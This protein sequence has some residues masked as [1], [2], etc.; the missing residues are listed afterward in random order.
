MF[1]LTQPRK[2]KDKVYKYYS[3][4][5]SYREGKKVHIEILHRVGR[6]SDQEACQ[7][8]AILKLQSGK[9]PYVTSLEEVIFS[10]HWAYLDVATL[11]HKW[12]ELGLSSCF[13]K[14][15]KGSDVSTGEIAKILTFN[16][17]LAPG[18]KLYTSRWVRKTTLNHIIDIDY[19]KVNDF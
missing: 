3:V 9:G 19:D 7:M 18:S 17:C 11:N 10:D 5:R 14:A 4:A 2:K 16:R 13:G 15:I 1:L 8:R 12:E 6:L